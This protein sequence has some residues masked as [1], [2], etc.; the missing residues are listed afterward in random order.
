MIEAGGTPAWK[1]RYTNEMLQTRFEA[2]GPAITKAEFYHEHHVSGPIFLDKYFQWMPMPKKTWKNYIVI[3]GYMD[4]SFV[5]SATSDFKAVRVWGL[6][7]EAKKHCLKSFVQRTSLIAC[8]RFMSSFDDICPPGV[9]VIWYIEKQFFNEQIVDALA[10]H[11][12][13]RE[14]AGLKTLNLIRDDRT[15][16]NKY[17]RIVTMEAEY[18]LGNVYYNEEEMY[19][20]DMEEGNNQLK[21]IEPGYTSPDDSPDADEGNWFKLNQHKPARNWEPLIGNIPKDRLY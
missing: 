10:E 13:Q 19:N 18:Q 2:L 6:T 3:I 12:I 21:A 20:N 14:A 11:N 15:K 8:F 7:P 1:E 9:G 16:E 5:N 17:T 4:P